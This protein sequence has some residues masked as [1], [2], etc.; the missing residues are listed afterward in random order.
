MSGPTPCAPGTYRDATLTIYSSCTDCP[1]GKYCDEYAMESTALS[2][3]D[4]PAGYYC[5]LKTADFTKYICFPGYY[6]PAGSSAPLDCPS[7]KY[8]EAYGLA[9]GTDCEGGY[10]CY[11][12][13][14][15]PNPDDAGIT[16]Y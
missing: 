12:N 4:C 16:G 1:A 15:V 3:K 9:I 14:K 13:S 8:C 6:C 11:K 2:G 10:F 7:G 5:P